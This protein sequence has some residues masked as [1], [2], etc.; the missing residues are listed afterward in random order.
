MTEPRQRIKHIPVVVA[1]VVQETADTVTLLLDAG[2]DPR[3][4]KAGQYV[5]I[6]PHQF[7]GDQ[8]LRGLPRGQQGPQGAAARLLDGVDAGRALPGHHGQGGA[9]RQDGDEV[10]AAAVAVPRA[11]PAQGRAHGS[12]RLRRRLP[13]ARRH[14]QPHRPRRAPVRRLRQRA[15]R[16]DDQV[17]PGQRAVAAP[18]L[19]LLEQDLERHHLPRRAGADGGG[20]PGAPARRPRADPRAG[21]RSP[22]PTRCGAAASRPT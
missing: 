13:P 10:S 5:S 2:D 17:G 3:D 16:L 20:A 18:D 19:H 6:D 21:D 9:L 4:Y 11:P 12:D 1:D 15:Q 7:A 22:T 14:R 8:G